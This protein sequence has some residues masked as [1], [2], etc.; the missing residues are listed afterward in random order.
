MPHNGPLASLEAIHAE[1]KSRE[2]R[3]QMRQIR[4]RGRFGVSDA[5]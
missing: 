3:R 4:R 2:K 1:V 5:G